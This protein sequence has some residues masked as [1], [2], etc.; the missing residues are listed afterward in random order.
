M[1]MRNAALYAALDDLDAYLRGGDDLPLVQQSALQELR[2]G[3]LCLVKVQALHAPG[4][5]CP[6]CLPAWPALL[7][8]SSCGK[9]HTGLAPA[10]LMCP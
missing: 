9:E 2:C 5:V 4:L 1:K 6:A 8:C 10:A 7:S 3:L